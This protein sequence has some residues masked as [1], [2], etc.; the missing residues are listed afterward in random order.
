[1]AATAALFA[2]LRRL[3]VVDLINGPSVVVPR[4]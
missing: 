4:V 3:S 1:M 2:E